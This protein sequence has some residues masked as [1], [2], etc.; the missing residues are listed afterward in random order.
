MAVFWF[1]TSPGRLASSPAYME[2][3][4][5]FDAGSLHCSYFKFTVSLSRD[6]VVT[7]VRI[8]A[9]CSDTWGEVKAR[10]AAH[11]K[12]DCSNMSWWVNAKPWKDTDRFR[13]TVLHEVLILACSFFPRYDLEPFI[14]LGGT[15]GLRRT[16]TAAQVLF[17]ELR[18]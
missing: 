14:T 6:S 17:F 2:F 10:I 5:L 16:R 8:H 4:E 12:I 3:V 13:D 9:S 1:D 7:S 15:C 11:H 18:G